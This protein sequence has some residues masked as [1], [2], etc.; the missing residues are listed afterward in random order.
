[1]NKV[2]IARTDD[3]KDDIVFRRLYNSASCERREKT[4]R[5]IFRKD[6]ML[7][8][9]AEALLRKALFDRGIKNF[10]I[11]YG[12]NGKPYI[13]GGGIY[14]NLSHSEETVI[15]AV[16][17][18]EVGAD[19]EKVTD[20]DFEIAN[21]FF[22]RAEYEMLMR[23]RTYEEKRD[24]FFRLWTLKESFLKATGFGMSLPANSFCIDIKNNEISVFQ[25][26]SKETYYFREYDFNDGYKYAVCGLSPHFED[27]I[28]FI[29][30]C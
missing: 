25:N 2:Y 27:K 20:I 15:C 5:L 28:E 1:M 13:G 14:F 10:T 11:E 9:L 26:V 7:S 4:D 23:Q 30:F 16:S 3:L 8:L 6:K 22:H 12:K 21:K 29:S 17:D 24:M 19:V 18:K